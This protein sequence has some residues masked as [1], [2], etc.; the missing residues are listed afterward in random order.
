M[1][2]ESS[3]TAGN[4]KKV[5]GK[6]FTKGD[7]RINRKGRPKNFDALRNLAQSISH[8]PALGADGKP[9]VID[10]HIITV[11]EIIMR[12]WMQSKNPQLQQ[13]FINYA[14]GKVPDKVENTGK[15]GA[16]IEIISIEV[17]KPD[18]E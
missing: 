3:N 7:P 6:P 2:D 1:T 9:I 10:G 17:I 11:A 18:G 15:D 14:Y 4:S 8:E 12:Q 13:A 5:P 16:P